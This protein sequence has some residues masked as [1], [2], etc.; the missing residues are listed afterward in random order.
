[1]L[2][3]F[4]IYLLKF[5]MYFIEPQSPKP[6]LENGKCDEKSLACGDGT[7]LPAIYFCDGSIDCPDG[8]DESWCGE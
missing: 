6:L 2:N 5:G 4:R 1:M 8:S 7:C 3:L